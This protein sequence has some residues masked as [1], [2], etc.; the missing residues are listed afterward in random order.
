MA[1]QPRLALA[2]IPQHIVQR[3]NDRQACF[4]TDTDRERYL[5]AM[6]EASLTNRCAIH[7]Y[8]LMTNHV[9][10]LATPM[11]APGVSAMM[12]QLGRR[13]VSGFNAL[14]GRTG[15]LWEGRFKS[16][17]VDTDRYV[18]SCYRYIE[19]NPVRAGIA[20]TPADYRWSSHACNASGADDA[21]ISAHPAFLAL[22]AD[23]VT[24]RT[25][26]EALVRESI[27]PQEL[28]ELRGHLQQQKVYGSARFQQAIEQMLARSTALRD[29]GRPRKKS[30]LSTG[31]KCT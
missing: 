13:Y 22:G 16:C 15:T 30:P 2:G 28:T 20:A 29:R 4:Y 31:K 7:A 1:R 19:M 10:L 12:Q 21:V 24:R 18:L 17:L 26:Y 5:L 3:G 11:E 14:H 9:H 6:R 8:V 27:A 25:T 23:P